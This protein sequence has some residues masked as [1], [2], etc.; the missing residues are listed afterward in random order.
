MGEQIRITGGPNPSSIRVTAVGDDG[1][2]T[3]LHVLSVTWRAT[4]MTELAT[5]TLEVL[6]DVDVVGVAS[7]D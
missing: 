3:V 5:A 1:R 2:E 4:G 6:A 7:A